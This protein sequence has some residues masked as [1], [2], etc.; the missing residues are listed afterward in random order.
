MRIEVN[1]ELDRLHAALEKAFAVLKKG[2]RIA[3]ISYHSLE[4][5]IVK[6]F[7][8]EKQQSCICPPELPQCVCGKMSELKM[9]SRK[10]ILPSVEEIKRNPR[11]RSAKL[12]VAEKIT[13]YQSL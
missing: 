4:D 2:G 9:V 7:F 1:R 5:R 12:R 10:P 8:K 3:V 6:G 13:E 11:A